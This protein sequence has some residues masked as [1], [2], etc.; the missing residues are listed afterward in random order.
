MRAWGAALLVVC[1][2]S[3]AVG[4]DQPFRR[5]QVPKPEGE[6]MVC[7]TWG[8][9]Q[10]T[11]VLDSGGSVRTPGDSEFAAVEAAVASWQ[12]L[13]TTCSDFTFTQQPRAVSTKVGKGTDT[14]NTMVFREKAC[15]D[16]APDSDLCFADGTCG[17]VYNCWDHSDFTIG[18]T[19]TTFSTRTG[20]IYDADIELNASEHED[21]SYFLFTAVSSPPCDIGKETTACVATDIQNTVT[22]EFGHFVGFDHVLNVGSTMEPTAPIGE[23]QKRILDL[24]TS[25]GFCTTYPRN[26]PPVPCDELAQT[27]RK[28]VANGN[29]TPGLS[30]IGCQAVGGWPLV[31]LALVFWFR[32]TWLATRRKWQADARI[33]PRRL[34][35]RA[36]RDPR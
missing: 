25:E 12:S 24:G 22:H 20:V 34:G 21:G 27:R 18:L 33:P 1:A 16:V 3:S 14:Q 10:V 9:R 19:T 23:T 28:I 31:A 26:L 6:P 11:F 13:S 30:V 2:A 5:T 7:V 36:S 35:A 4:Q 32:L 17:N 29:G 15:R 8:K